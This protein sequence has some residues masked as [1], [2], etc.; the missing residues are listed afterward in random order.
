MEV[1]IPVHTYLLKLGRLHTLNER[2]V[3]YTT[4]KRFFKRCNAKS[5]K[6]NRMKGKGVCLGLCGQ[7]CLSEESIFKLRMEI[8]ELD[9][10]VS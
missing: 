7:R 2:L 8:D 4:I 3:S 6:N 9:L 5:Y 10:G 1:L